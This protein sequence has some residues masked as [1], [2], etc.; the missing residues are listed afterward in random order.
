MGA[1]TQEGIVTQAHWTRLFLALERSPE[2]QC[3]VF[4]L[5]WDFR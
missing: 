2:P 1:V 5:L 4:L 3:T